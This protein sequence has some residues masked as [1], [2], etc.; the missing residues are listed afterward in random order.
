MF[1]TVTL[2]LMGVSAREDFVTDNLSSD[3]LADDLET[4]LDVCEN[5]HI[6]AHITV[7]KP[8]NQPIFGSTVFRLV[9]G[10]QSLASVIVGLPLSSPLILGLK[11]GVVGFTF[12]FLCKR[13]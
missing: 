4:T 11:P 5:L 1:D 6:Y 13:L 8:N 2:E 12:D 3:N 7:G 10:N 9:L